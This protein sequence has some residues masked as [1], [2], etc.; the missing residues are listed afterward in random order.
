MLKSQIQKKS[1]VNMSK[2]RIGVVIYTK[3][4]TNTSILMDEFRFFN[5]FHAANPDCEFVFIAISEFTKKSILNN[6]SELNLSSS[7]DTMVSQSTNNL[8]RDINIAVRDID[9]WQ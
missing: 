9:G 8:A 4:G 2:I 3:I 5:N 7:G 1:N 6:R